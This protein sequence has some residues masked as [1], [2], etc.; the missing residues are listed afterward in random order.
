M[1]AT[2]FR[3]TLDTT[4][5][6]RT[7]APARTTPPRSDP[8]GSAPVSGIVDIRD[9][10]G[11]VRTAGYAP[12]PDD[13]TITPGDLR[14]WGLRRGDTVTGAARQDAAGKPHRDRQATLVR[15]DTIAGR[16]VDTATRRPDF[17]DQTALY[18]QQRLR[19]ETEPQLLTTRVIDLLM[20]IGKGQRALVA[21]PP[22]AG[23]TMILQA[24]AHAISVNH[25]DCHLMAVLVD[26]R[27]EEVTDMRRTIHGEVVASTFDRPPAEHTAV[28]ELA[29][30][31]A[32]R[33]AETGRDVVILL[34]SITRLGRAYNLAA[35]S[36]GRTL[37]GGIDAGALHAPKRLLGAARNLEGGGS[38]TIIATALVDTGSSGDGLIFEEFKSTGNADLRLKRSVADRRVFPA[39]DVEA[40]GTRHEELLLAPDELVLVRALRRALHPQQGTEAL[41]ERL[42]RTASNAEFLRSLR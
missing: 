3:S 1:T 11:V 21:A 33:L 14:R 8:D 27:P 31:R 38:L 13:V 12:D 30:E 23:K 26:E 42:R 28:A 25:P 9:Q 16:P 39:V 4:V 10:R 29:V 36:G 32:K 2:L 35:P 15:L 24:I 37:S 18:P 40:T 17:H 6:R 19:L 34:D 20:P 7:P 22:K 5:V 41:I